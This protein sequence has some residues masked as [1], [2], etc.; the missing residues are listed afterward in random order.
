MQSFLNQINPVALFKKPNLVPRKKIRSYITRILSDGRHDEK[1]VNAG[2]NI[3]TVFS[4]YVHASSEN[5]MDMYGG[6]PSH[7]HLKGMQETSRMS[8]H[9]YD[10][11]NYFYRGLL[12]TTLVAKGN[13][14]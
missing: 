13:S 2:E 8:D 1:S 3:S 5:I 11:W 7:F 6:D 14:A 10:A 9:T 4:G 12:S